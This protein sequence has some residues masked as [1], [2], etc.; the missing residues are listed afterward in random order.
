MKPTQWDGNQNVGDVTATQ[1]NAES[2]KG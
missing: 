2:S 1:E